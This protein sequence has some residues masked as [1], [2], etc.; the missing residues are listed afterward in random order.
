MAI[1]A[2][3]IFV[4]IQALSYNGYMQINYDRLKSDV[5]VRLT[6]SVLIYYNIFCLQTFLDLNGDGKVD[7]SDAEN[8]LAKVR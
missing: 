7:G 3:G 1:I 4:T 5:E 6:T 8:A 2:G